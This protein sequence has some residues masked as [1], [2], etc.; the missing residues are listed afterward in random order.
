MNTWVASALLLG[1]VSN[2]HCIG[3]C[4]PISL[5][6]PLNRSSKLSILI[7]LIQYNFGRL[8][9]YMIIGYLIGFIG[10]GIQLVGI[11]Q[12]ISI[13]SGILIIFYAWRKPLSRL[14]ML[15]SFGDKF[16]FFPT[17]AMGTILKSKYP[18]K[19]ILLGIINGLLPCG[20][21]YT[22]LIAS[23]LTGNP[24]DSALS[25]MFFGIGTLPGM[26]I[27]AYL[28]NQMAFSFKSKINRYLP[29]IISL[30]GLLIIIRGMNLDIPFI[31]PKS[32]LTDS[33][34]EIKLECC[35]TKPMCNKK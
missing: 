27:I 19:L 10:L 21:V 7:G 5:A 26:I 32:T 4:G 14:K 2:L 12:V 31:S 23:I 15:P 34:K 9:T 24:I 29:Y 6:L 35:H 33:K 11:L 1:V 20:M 18:F 3:M 16:S 22:A 25:M 30:I 8:L 17:N 13:I 28:A